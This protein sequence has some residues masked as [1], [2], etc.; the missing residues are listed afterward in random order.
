[1][2]NFTSKKK[3]IIENFEIIKL[4][5][6]RLQGKKINGIFKIQLKKKIKNLKIFI[7]LDNNRIFD[8]NYL[9]KFDLKEKKLVIEKIIPDDYIFKINKNYF[10]FFTLNLDVDLN[11]YEKDFENG[12]ISTIKKDEFFFV[13]NIN[14][15]N[16]KKKYISLM[17]FDFIE[18]NFSEFKEYFL[19]NKKLN[20]KILIQRKIYSNGDCLNIFVSADNKNNDKEILINCKFFQ[21]WKINNDK[22][23][24]NK[25]KIINQFYLEKI[26][27]F[28]K[29]EII[30][31]LNIKK[32]PISHRSNIF[33]M[34]YKL[35]IYVQQR[36]LF[37]YKTI[38]N[39]EFEIEIFH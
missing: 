21:I 13:L 15:K 2:G 29:I 9:K 10:V 17:D 39:F 6:I 23:N 35:V 24:Y 30:K 4:S 7:Y 1:M 19:K 3:M 26:I 8:E 34:Y 37:S 11:I 22:K 38:K 28:K 20:L 27:P 12:K 18:N 33:N 5:N 16:F 25:K 32:L 31:K 14:Q 36:K